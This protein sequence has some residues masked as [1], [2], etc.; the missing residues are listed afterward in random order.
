MKNL[1]CWA[2][3]QGRVFKPTLCQPVPPP[4]IDHGI[5]T[6]AGMIGH[7][8]P[9]GTAYGLLTKDE[10]LELHSALHG[11]STLC[12][13]PSDGLQAVMLEELAGCKAKEAMDSQLPGM[14]FFPWM[15]DSSGSDEVSR[16]LLIGYGESFADLLTEDATASCAPGIVF[17]VGR[18]YAR[19]VR[20]RR[21]D[22][23]DINHAR[24]WIAPDVKTLENIAPVVEYV[25]T[26][27]LTDKDRADFRAAENLTYENRYREEAE[28]QAGWAAKLASG[29]AV[30]DPVSGR[31]ML[32]PDVQTNPT[33]RKL[34]RP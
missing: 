24:D 2:L 16:I 20:N 17:P 33:A 30:I 13:M 3:I 4:P 8:V 25:R 18:V 22:E 15:E 26:L 14:M 12:F 29:E 19:P 21:S 10:A 28:Y 11:Y 27:N 31:A 7:D 6:I 9:D 5:G 1:R 32:K 23:R 34:L